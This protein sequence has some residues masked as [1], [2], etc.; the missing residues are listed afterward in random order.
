MVKKKNII[1]SPIATIVL[2][3]F[4]IPG[5]ALSQSKSNRIELQRHNLSKCGIKVFGI[6]RDGMFLA[7]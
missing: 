1:A 6:A 2:A 5:S 7:A 4:M 3:A